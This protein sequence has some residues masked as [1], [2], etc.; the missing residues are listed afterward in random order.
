MN[1]L[2]INAHPDFNQLNHY[3]LKLQKAFEEKFSKVFPDDQLT[4]VNLYESDIPNISQD[5]L[6]AAWS[7]K[8]Q[9]IL[10][11]SASLLT[12]FKLSHRIVITTPL[13]NFNIPS[14]L[15]DY[16]DNLMIARETFRYLDIADSY[17]KV[18]EGLMTD[19]YRM[20]V[21]VAQGSI[22][23]KDNI[24]SEIDYIP[25][26][27]QTIFEEMMGF[28]Y[29]DIIRAEG[30]AMLDE[31]SIMASALADLDSKFEQFFKC[32]NH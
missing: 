32:S 19:D 4:I 26:Y 23:T 15:K 21:L 31:K 2:I 25:M 10:E 5:G 27:L 20:L 14:K 11:Q 9:C 22:Y 1:T 8:D 24:Y 18:S 13:H 16:I 12:Q 29:F 30:T 3:S 28:D 6:L 17:G 7:G